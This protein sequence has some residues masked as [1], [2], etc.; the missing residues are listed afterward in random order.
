LNGAYR[1]LGSL[2]R[3]FDKKT[4]MDVA[5]AKQISAPLTFVAE[6]RLPTSHGVLRVRAYRSATGAKPLAIIAGDLKGARSVPV[7][8]HDA[9][10]TSEAL[11]SLK[12]DCAQQLDLA[13]K[14]IAE[15]GQGMV[16]YLPQ[17]GRGIGL[18]NKIAVYAQQEKGYDTVQANTTLGFPA[19]NRSYEAASYI[20]NEVGIE[21]IA[22]LSNNPHKFDSLK[23][24]GIEIEARQPILVQPNPHSHNYLKVKM[25]KMGHGLSHIAL[26]SQDVQKVA[27]N[28]GLL[29]VRTLFELRD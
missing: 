20:I 11:G 25:S 24:L 15:N 16:I 18:A 21:S 9:C 27:T 7:R 6:T 19:E 14:H 29:S 3:F 8:V 22:L 2:E 26:D 12:C 10:L 1:L 13:L 28:N 4:S 5:S 23:A 17:E